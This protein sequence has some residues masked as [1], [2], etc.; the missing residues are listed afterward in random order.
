MV[1]LLGER[2][3][4]AKKPIRTDFLDFRTRAARRAVCARE[5]ELNRR[6]APDVYLGVVEL[7]DPDG[8]AEAGE[9]LVVMRRMPE[10]ARLSTLV[11]AGGCEDLVG[12]I[13]GLVA[14]F[15]ARARRGPDVD[16]EG[17]TAAVRRRWQ[18][19]LRETRDL[20]S[21]VLGDDRLGRI[22]RQVLRY[23]DG[24]APL[25]TARIDAGRIVDGHGDLLADDIFR[26]PD[27]PRILDCLEF[28]DRL[29]YLDGIDDIACLAM[30][31]EYLGRADLAAL[32]FERYTAAATDPAPTSL[33]HHY[34]AYRAFMRA[35]V[36]CVRYLQGRVESADDARRHTTLAEEHLAAG[37]VRLAIVG[38]L[39]ATGKSTVARALADTVG[40]VLVS[41]DAVRREM[42]ADARLRDPDPGYGRGRYAE[43]ATERVYGALLARAAHALA[44]GESVVL[45]AS[46]TDAARRQRAADVAAA[47]LA[48]LVPIQCTAPA[49]VTELR[50][51]ERAVTGRDHDSEATP[52]VANTMARRA[53]PW[54]GATRI[55]TSGEVRDAAA[56]AVAR[57]ADE[58]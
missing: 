10:D 36:D 53:D 39:P 25:F 51:R 23:L 12:T 7:G 30:D 49:G 6:L 34:V 19:N 32:L 31:L 44:H 21:A 1:F 28:D 5:V 33:R 37:T 4:K 15:H 35:K 9:P 56:A 38:G 8:A 26:L 2:V 3:Y 27:G 29:R 54:P 58:S 47:H 11:D 22:E 43:E 57:W 48:D 20:G 46:W 17:T 24:R 14:R 45:D 13:A 16:A 50:L 52:D 40:A 42:F 41:S 55:D 18:N